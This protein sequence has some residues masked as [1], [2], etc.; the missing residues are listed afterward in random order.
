MAPVLIGAVN[1]G[2]LG[3]VPD[4]RL[5]RYGRTEPDWFRYMAG[6]PLDALCPRL[7]WGCRFLRVGH[8]T[9]VDKVRDEEALAVLSMSKL[10][11]VLAAEATAPGDNKDQKAIAEKNALAERAKSLAAIEGVF[12]RARSLRFAVLTESLLY[13]ADLIGANLFGADLT[14]ANLIGASPSGAVMMNSL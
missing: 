10:T 3:T 14:D 7:N 12:L 9:L 6:N 5:V 8:R 2:Y 1:L 11:D 13:G 4:A